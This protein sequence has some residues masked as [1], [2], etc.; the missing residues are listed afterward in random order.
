[1]LDG[2]IRQTGGTIT[3]NNNVI[4]YKEIIKMTKKTLGKSL[5][6]VSLICLLVFLTGCTPT[7]SEPGDNNQNEEVFT[8]EEI[9]SALSSKEEEVFQITWSS[10]DKMV[11]YIQA[12]KPEK[13]GLD[14]AY[15]WKVGEEEA[16]YVRDVSPTTHGFG[17]S[18]DSKYFLI[19]EKLG[20]GAINS[21]VKTD[22]LQEETYKP[23]SFGIPVW[24]PDSLAIA[25][26]NE[27]HEYGE[28]W[29]FLEV[30]K[31]GQ[32]ESEYIWKA[33]GYLYKVESWDKEGNIGYTE[34]NDQGKETKKTTKNIRPDIS[35]VHLGDSKEQVEAAL[36]KDYQETPPSGE[37]GHFPEQVYRWDYDGYKIFIG[38]ESGEV[39][40]L[41]VTSPQAETNLGVKMGDTAAKV[42]EVYRSKYIEPESIHGGKLYG[43]F[44]VEGAAALFFRF[45]LKEGE[46]LEDIK[47][48][49]KVEGMTLT[50]P[51][52]MDDSF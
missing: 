47:P 17:W 51:E 22:T 45:D 35:G 42:F 19:S 41:Y 30:Y 39:L 49:N 23:K 24:S 36:G 27:F 11:V 14:E 40:E 21:I 46:W 37:T 50:Y 32:A 31:L 44:K 4:H 29:G 25:Y 12:G 18:P 38:A 5:I 20:E 26:G 48:E 8:K 9:Q 13:E 16:K 1:M 10:D 15:L 33:R 3:V 6:G 43:I 2:N 52:I 34:I 28:S 7:P